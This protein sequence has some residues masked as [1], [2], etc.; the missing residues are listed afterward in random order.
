MKRL[1]FLVLASAL[2]TQAHALRCGHRVVSVGDYDF[3]VAAR[4]G[5]P[6]HVGTLVAYPYQVEAY[7]SRHPVVT[8][9]P[10]PIVVD[11]WVYNFGANRLLYLLEFEN[12]RL[13]RI[14]TRGRGY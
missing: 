14:R 5:E 8:Y 10:F 11:Q 6:A 4:C 12:G 3:E 1:T 7:R 9:L 2:A 13:V